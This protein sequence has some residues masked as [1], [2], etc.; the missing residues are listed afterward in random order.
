MPKKKKNPNTMFT[1]FQVPF[2]NI[3]N[4]LSE[5]DLSV[6]IVPFVC[7]CTYKCGV[8]CVSSVVF[9]PLCNVC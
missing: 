2:T 9:S 6:R 3:R 1:V 8:A 5:S 7:A 4:E